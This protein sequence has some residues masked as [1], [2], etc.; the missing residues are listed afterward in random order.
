MKTNY[1]LNSNLRSWQLESTTTISCPT[2]QF[3]SS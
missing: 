1:Q 3:H 2:F